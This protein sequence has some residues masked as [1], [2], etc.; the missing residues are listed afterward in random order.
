MSI[1]LDWQQDLEEEGWP[2]RPAEQPPNRPGRNRL[3]W[4]VLLG[5]ALVAAGALVVWR[6]SERGTAAA[7]ADIQ[8]AITFAHWAVQRNDPELLRRS[9]DPI[10]PLWHEHLLGEWDTLIAAARDAPEPVVESVTLRGDIAEAAVRWTD[11]SA[12][13]GMRTYLARRWYRLVGDEWRWTLP[14]REPPDQQR[15][16]Q[17]AH[18]TLAY[19]AADEE[20]A[21]AVLPGLDQFIGEQCQRYGVDA[22]QCAFHLRWDVLGSDDAPLARSDLPLPALASLTSRAYG[23]TV[24][25]AGLRAGEWHSPELRERL[26]QFF[27]GRSFINRARLEI[28]RPAGA[29]ALPDSRPGAAD[30]PILL[31]SPRLHGIDDAGQPHP[32]WQTQ[33]RRVL[34]DAVLRQT[35]GYVLGPA[36]YVDAAW[37]LH[38]ALLALLEQGAPRPA[39]P[40]AAD[41][42]VET[43][44]HVA[45][46]ELASLGAALQAGPDELALAQ[47][48]GLARYLSSQWDRAALDRLPA[49]MGRHSS[50][51][52]LLQDAL[53]SDAA[54]FMAGWRAAQLAEAGSPLAALMEDLQ[55]HMRSE[56]IARQT[57]DWDALLRLYT[58]AGRAWFR[59]RQNGPLYEPVVFDPDWQVSINDFGAIGDSVWVELEE[60]NHE[61]A[62]VDLRFYRWQEEDGWRRDKPN[63]LFWGQERS[64]QTELARW[65]YY[66]ID[67]ETVAAL[68]PRV[69]EHVRQTLADLALPL[70]PITIT[71]MAD[72]ATDWGMM[73]DGLDV[74]VASPRNYALDRIDAAGEAL[75]QEIVLVMVYQQIQRKVARVTPPDRAESASIPAI[76]ILRYEMDRMELVDFPFWREIDLAAREILAANGPSTLNAILAPSQNDRSGLVG[77]YSWQLALYVLEEYGPQWIETLLYQEMRTVMEMVA[78]ENGWE[79]QELEADWQRYL[80]ER[81]ASLGS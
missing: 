46:P 17:A 56:A 28:L 42:A 7:K 12:A 78:S 63:P 5:L 59:T 67:E 1:K 8:E 9:L 21:A 64:R 45:L 72:T 75:R 29:T 38:Q 51:N 76:A 13:G 27:P 77:S 65:F 60:K 69:D 61:H 22:A 43:A 39:P 25:M 58:D 41:A 47:L 81:W 10:A 79:W 2:R 24:T 50:L 30:Q 37:A 54:T 34:A 68:A 40:A 53:D 49:A 33:A 4:A 31:P 73:E 74:V 66:E 18:L 16:Q 48:D 15:S 57:G 32:T 35:T 55:A 26:L 36:R 11:N 70:N 23:E 14:R 6:L 52:G 3:R 20:I 62:Q 80:S 71:V 19:Y 44:A